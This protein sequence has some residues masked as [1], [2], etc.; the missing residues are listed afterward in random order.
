[1]AANN[2]FPPII[3]DYLPAFLQADNS[4]KIVFRLPQFNVASDFKLD[5]TQLTVSNLNT[6]KSMLHTIISK[7]RS[8]NGINLYPFLL[9]HVFFSFAE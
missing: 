6:N 5:L 2:L 7:D 1:M 3:D 4:C 8:D 9:W